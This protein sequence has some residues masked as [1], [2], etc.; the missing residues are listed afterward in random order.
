MTGLVPLASRSRT[1]RRATLALLTAL[2]LTP[3]GS[4]PTRAD[5]PDRD[6]PQHERDKPNADKPNARKPDPKKPRHED[7]PPAAETILDAYIEATGGKK[8]YAKLRTRISR[9]TIQTEGLGLK[10]TIETWA[11][12]PDL[13]YSAVD[14]GEQGKIERGH[15]GRLAW[16]LNPL[17]G[18]RRLE[19]AERAFLVRE[20]T[21]NADLNWRKVCKS[22]ET[23]GSDFVDGSPVWKVRALT[24]DGVEMTLYYDKYSKLLVRLDTTV[25]MEL[26]QVP[27]EV[28]PANYK[29]A[30]GVLVPFKSTQKML[31]LTQ[32]ATFDSIQFNKP[33]PRGRFTPPDAVRHLPEKPAKR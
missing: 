20:A 5:P 28:Y 15:D 32:T 18:P 30:N 1:V 25:K 13:L 33:I 8:A 27:V 22:V 31:G 3:P 26:G 17:T 24:R 14:M 9:G 23:I 10:Q 6:K 2:L 12:A 4:A 21:F 29:K 16:E 7:D 19:G 11:A